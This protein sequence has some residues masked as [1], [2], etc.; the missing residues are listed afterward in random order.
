VTS[1]SE[2]LK[3]AAADER[4]KTSLQAAGYTPAWSPPEAFEAF[5]QQNI[6]DWQEA[7]D[8]AGLRP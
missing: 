8:A 3:H 2:A 6:A 4:Y 1:L 5:L 7:S